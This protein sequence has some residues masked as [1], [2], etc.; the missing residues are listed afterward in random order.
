MPL[1]RP[2]HPLERILTLPTLPFHYLRARSAYNAI[3]GS[4]N[5]IF[6]HPSSKPHRHP[7]IQ[8]NQPDL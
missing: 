4:L 2:E 5:A 8:Q 1:K 3:Y 7:Q 6:T